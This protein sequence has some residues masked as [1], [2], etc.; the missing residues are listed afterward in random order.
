MRPSRWSKTAIGSDVDLVK[1]PSPSPTTRLIPLFPITS[2]TPQSKCPH[3][4]PLSPD[5]DFVCMVCYQAGKDG[6]P[7]LP[8][9]VKPPPDP[10]ALKESA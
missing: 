5:S 3:K 4:R 6:T 2:F 10:P 9:N 7:A 8:R 1:V